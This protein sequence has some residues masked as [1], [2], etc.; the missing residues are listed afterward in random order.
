MEPRDPDVGNFVQR[1]LDILFVGYMT[2]LFLPVMMNNNSEQSII[3]LLVRGFESLVFYL[4]A[5]YFLVIAMRSKT[6]GREVDFSSVA[7]LFA[8][9]STVITRV[10]IDD[11]Q[12]M[13]GFWVLIVLLV[14]HLVSIMRWVATTRD[15]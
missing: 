1:Q 11:S 12:I 3:S 14:F 15:K 2:I 7:L 10:I 13:Y 9:V 5:L 8:I 4:L 6:L